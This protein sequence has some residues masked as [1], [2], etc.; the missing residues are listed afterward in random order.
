MS[1]KQMPISAALTP[2]VFSLPR[3]RVYLCLEMAPGGE[4]YGLLQ[5]RGTF[6]EA[7]HEGQKPCHLGLRQTVPISLS[8]HLPCLTAV[9]SKCTTSPGRQELHGTSSRWWRLNRSSGFSCFA[10]TLFLSP[11]HPVLPLEAHHS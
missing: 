2:D 6:S 4:L 10:T 8:W 9:C 3:K 7:R 5:S 1:L 11:G